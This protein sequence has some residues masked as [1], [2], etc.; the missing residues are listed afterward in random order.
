MAQLKKD[1][2]RKAAILFREQQ[3]QLHAK[4]LD[5]TRVQIP[6]ASQIKEDEALALQLQEKLNKEDEEREKQKA[7]EAKFRITDSELAK[8]MREEWIVVL[9][10]QANKKS[11][12][13]E[14]VRQRFRRA[15]AFNKR[16]HEERKVMIDFLKERGESGKR[17]GPMNFMNLQAL[18]R[19]VKKEEEERLKKTSSTRRLHTST[20][21]RKPK[22]PKTTPLVSLPF[23]QKIPSHSPRIPSSSPKESKSS[24]LAPSHQQP[25]KKKSKPLSISEDSRMIVQWFYSDP[26]Q[27]FEV[28]RGEVEMKRSVFK[29]VDEVMQLPDYDIKKI[30]ELGETHEPDNESGRR[31]LLMIK[32]HFNPFK[33]VIID[34]KPLQSHFTLVKWSC[35]T[36]KDEYTLM[37]VRGHN[38]RCSSK[39]IF[40]MPSKDIKSLSEIP[41]VNPSKDPRGYETARIILNMPKL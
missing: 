9:I 15:I 28:F 12:E 2:E 35:N 30:M 1:Q 6:A 31:P 8:E 36:V 21:E 41:F 10:S 37:D 40:S 18:Y 17:L 39:A 11:T 5:K 14:K 29:S 32:H 38:M 26:D 22:K 25:P 13:E 3:I 27:W 16:T 20:E 24:H 4:S 33:D 34:A 19:K 23:V 7:E